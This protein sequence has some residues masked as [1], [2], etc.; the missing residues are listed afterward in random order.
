M[1]LVIGKAK[2]PFF[3]SSFALSVKLSLFHPGATQQP[4]VV[5]VIHSSDLTLQRVF[6]TQQSV[7]S[8][9]AYCSA[10]RNLA[11]KRC[12]LLISPLLVN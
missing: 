6:T 1:D 7:R 11:A 9:S 4:S 8:P 3:L 10:R 12:P 2:A 5:C